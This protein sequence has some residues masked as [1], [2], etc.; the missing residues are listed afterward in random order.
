LSADDFQI[1]GQAVLALIF[2]VG[3]VVYLRLVT[4]LASTGGQV[5]TDGLDLPDLLVSFVLL[6]AFG[7][8]AFH[9]IMSGDASAEPA[10]PD[11][12]LQNSAVFVG[13]AAGVVA[14]LYARGLRPGTLF[15][16]S[17]IGPV[18]ALGWALLLLLAAFPF[19][20]LVNY[21]TT[22]LLKEDAVRQPMV[23]FFRNAAERHDY[24]AM[25]SVGVAAI[26][27]AP[28]CEE[29]FFRG[30]FYGVGKRYFGAW[31]SGALTAL[32]FAAIHANL[33]SLP[34]LFVL[35]V[36]LT[37]AYEGTGSLLV[38]MGM[39]ALFNAT[40]LSVL[41]AQGTGILKP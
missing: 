8:L 37:L 2:S 32:M 20:M 40:S 5:K 25:S 33:A 28:V 11:H 35:A 7:G 39:H 13:I 21:I 12:A 6:S 15:G 19:I 16:L 31:T 9:A 24:A 26:I 17:R 27:V 22:K 30:Y 1:G 3:I 36:A 14:L 10:K 38:P 18:R 4:Q 29:F 23:E 41:Y 34:G